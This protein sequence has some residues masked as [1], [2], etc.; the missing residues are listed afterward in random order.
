MSDKHDQSIEDD[1]RRRSLGLAK[2]GYAVQSDETVTMEMEIPW[3]GAK[4]GDKVWVDFVLAHPT[5][6]IWCRLRIEGDQ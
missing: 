2:V 5:D 1:Q 3:E 4:V 6:C